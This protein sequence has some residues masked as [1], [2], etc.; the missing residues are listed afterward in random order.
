M[1]SLSVN[2]FCSREK[3]ML[4]K[5]RDKKILDI[6]KLPSLEE[7][8]ALYE[9]DTKASSYVTESICRCYEEKIDLLSEVQHGKDPYK[10]AYFQ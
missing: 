3:D 6:G 5:V 2:S 10:D 7:L 4:A 1:L 9:Q 8:K